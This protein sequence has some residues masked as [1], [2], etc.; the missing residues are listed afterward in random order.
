MVQH[1]VSP[2]LLLLLKQPC[3]LLPASLLP[4]LVAQVE[5]VPR[6]W[7]QKMKDYLGTAPEDDAQGCL[8]VRLCWIRASCRAVG[9][10]CTTWPNHTIH[11]IGIDPLNKGL[12]HSSTS[13]QI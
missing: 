4:G 1:C 11:S 12:Q 2:L 8:Q 6:V 10:M 3:I 5:D 7:N 13:P 9:C